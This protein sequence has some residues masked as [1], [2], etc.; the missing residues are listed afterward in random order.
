MRVEPRRVRKREAGWGMV[1]VIL[2]TGL[3]VFLLLVL[4]LEVA[5]LA[6]LGGGLESQLYSFVLAENGL[7]FARSVMQVVD[8]NQLL[9]GR[10]GIFDPSRR[11]GWRNPLSLSQARAFE[12]SAEWFPE[13]D[14]GLPWNL[15]TGEQRAQLDLESGR[16]FIRFSNNPEEGPDMDLD[17]VLIARSMGIAESLDPAPAGLA[18]ALRNQAT[19]LE[20]RLRHSRYFHSPA[21]LILWESNFRN[22]RGAVHNDAGPLVGWV[23]P[24]DRAE[25]ALGELRNELSI[26]PEDAHAV[27]QNL[28]PFYRDNRHR[29]SLFEPGFWLDFL[30]RID[31]FVDSRS[32]EHLLY[33][34]E[35][36]VLSG[37]RD[38]LILSRGELWLESGALIQGLIL[39]IGEHDMTMQAGSALTG[40]VWKVSTDSTRPGSLL[41]E[42]GSRVEFN[43][44]AINRA[45]EALPA[46]LLEFRIIFPEMKQ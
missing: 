30:S 8:A 3:I 16:V 37:R 15:T 36:G 21:P 29:S 12:V 1:G 17:G 42:A 6:S 33:L 18:M 31:D 45:P 34:P 39:H 43:V 22:R 19:L 14:D 28:T 20:A 10:D 13:S 38:G 32:A 7:E 27:V 2:W 46:D 40:A 9:A 25:A 4:H 41:L 24:E 44:Q 23:G 35:G 11:N 26:G 5:N